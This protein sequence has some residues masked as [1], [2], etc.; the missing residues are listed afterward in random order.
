M[1]LQKT[2]WGNIEWMENN[3]QDMQRKRLH[4]GIVTMDLGT[5]HPPH[6]HYDEQ[7]N[8]IIQGEAVSYID[9]EVTQLKPGRLFHWPVGVVHEVYNVGSVPFIHLLISSAGGSVFDLINTDWPG[10]EKDE[11]IPGED[12]EQLLFRAVEAIRTQFLEAL[13]YPYSIYDRKNNLIC[14]GDT[15]PDFCKKKCKPESGGG[16]RECMYRSEWFDE[17][18]D[19]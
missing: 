2:A 9:G 13:G 18:G 5:H 8:Y 11:L 15:F 4:V 14:S 10:P 19:L 1:S 6:R 17:S 12:A 7:V 16:H 3:G